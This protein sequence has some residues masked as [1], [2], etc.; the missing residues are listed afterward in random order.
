MKAD[1]A[2]IGGG[3]AGIA[4]AVTAARSGAEVYLIERQGMLGGMASSAFVHSIC[5]LYQLRNGETDPLIDANAG[6]PKEFAQRLLESGGARGP[7]RMGRLDVVLHRPTCFAHLADHYVHTLPNLKLLLHSEIVDVQQKAYGEIDSLTIQC[8]KTRSVLKTT[9]VVDTTGDA[10]IARIAGASC[11]LAPLDS[12]QRPAYIVALGGVDP[13]AMKEDGRMLIAH[14]LSSA[15]ME[16]KLPESC[17]GMAFRSGVLPQEVWGTIDLAVPGFDPRDARSISQLEVEGRAIATQ[18]ISYLKTAL[19][20]FSHVTI[21]SFPCRAGIRE[22]LR[23]KGLYELSE[24]DILSGA[25]F[26]DEVSSSS[27]PIELRETA[28]GPRFRFPEQN[29]SCGIP[30]RSLCSAEIRN[31]LVAG[32]CISSS[33]EAQA[34]IRVIGTCMATGEAAGKAA[35]EI[36]DTG[37]LRATRQRG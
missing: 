14:T 31:L 6:F 34:A 35:A 5:G 1:V 24:Q 9:V 33:H 19:D 23:I 2:V 32:R 17:L 25:R 12:L 36:A 26:D 29:R 11:S 7:V 27:W 8:R 21:T 16:G 37:E 10:E 30:L 13:G 15:V 28:R 4:A 18:V 3:S 22:S 20:G